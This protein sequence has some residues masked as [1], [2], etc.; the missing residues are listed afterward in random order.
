MDWE[1]RGVA[2]AYKEYQLMIQLAGP[3][4]YT[5]TIDAGNRGWLP[6]EREQTHSQSYSIEIPDSLVPGVY[7]F[8]VKLRCPETN[9]DVSI[10]LDRQLVDQDGFYE[11]AQL[12]VQ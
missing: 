5:T 2:P 3:E 1:N 11:L 7:R 6:A 4:K 10:A 9:R 12:K 8:K